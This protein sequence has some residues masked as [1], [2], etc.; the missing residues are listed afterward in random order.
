MPPGKKRLPRLARTWANQVCVPGTRLISM[1]LIASTRKATSCVS[2]IP[3]SQAPP[4]PTG[5]RPPLLRARSMLAP[6]ERE[7]AKEDN[8]GHSVCRVS[9]TASL[10]ARGQQCAIRTIPACLA[11]AGAKGR[12]ST[13]RGVPG[14]HGSCWPF[15]FWSSP[16]CSWLASCGAGRSSGKPHKPSGS[17][18][19]GVGHGPRR[20]RCRHWRYAPDRVR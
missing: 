13:R 20:L 19:L 4:A 3:P 1:R 11:A 18:A 2:C 10:G 16:S 8:G 12:Q 7:P 17:F 9:T 14:G 6:N 5:R 15:G